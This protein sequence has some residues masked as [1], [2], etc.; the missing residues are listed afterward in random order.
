MVFVVK[1]IETY[2]QGPMI[3]FLQDL[4]G[5]KVYVAPVGFKS[6]AQYFYFEQSREANVFKK[7]RDEKF[8]GEAVLYTPLEV[9]VRQFMK[10]GDI[11]HD[12]YFIT[13]VTTVELDTIPHIDFLYQKGG[14]KFY[15]REASQWLETK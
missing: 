15:K 6:Y 2:S 3:E 13:K 9:Q 4:K 7:I 14:F 1:K 11:E 5:K 8:G 10:Y 12:A